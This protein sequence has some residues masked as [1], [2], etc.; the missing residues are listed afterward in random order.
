MFTALYEQLLLLHEPFCAFISSALLPIYNH[1]W[2][3]TAIIRVFEPQSYEPVPK[4]NEKLKKKT[5]LLNAT[6]GDFDCL[7]FLD[8]IEIIRVNRNVLEKNNA[9][10][11]DMK[12]FNLLYKLQI[13]RAHV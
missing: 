1:N 2:W 11:F 10:L 7:D 4:Q 5:A 3:Q 8:L 6:A 13:G 12:Y 9:S